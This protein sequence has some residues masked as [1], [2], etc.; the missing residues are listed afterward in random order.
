MDK[1]MYFEPA[2]EVVELQLQGALLQASEPGGVGGDDSADKGGE[3]ADDD[4]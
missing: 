3:G 1:K 2:M 4:F